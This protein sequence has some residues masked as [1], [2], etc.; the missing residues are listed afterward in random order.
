MEPLTKEDLSDISEEQETTKPTKNVVIG[1]EF[2]KLTKKAPK[3]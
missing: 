2:A 3:K 1:K